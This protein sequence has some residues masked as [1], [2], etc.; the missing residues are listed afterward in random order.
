MLLEDQRKS[1]GVLTEIT[2]LM[3]RQRAAFDTVRQSMVGVAPLLPT[4]RIDHGA[5]SIDSPLPL[6]DI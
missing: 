4:D 6:F 2:D 5:S 3:K 1:L